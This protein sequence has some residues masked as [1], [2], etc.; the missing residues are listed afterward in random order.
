MGGP[1][2]FTS[3]MVFALRAA[4]ADYYFA[5]YGKWNGEWTI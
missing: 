5:E 3:E 4:E 2:P 1:G